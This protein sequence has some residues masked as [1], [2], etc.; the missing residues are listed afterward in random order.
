[1][2]ENQTVSIC[3]DGIF[4]SIAKKSE[5]YAK[6]HADNADYTDPNDNLIHCGKCHT[7]KQ[8]R[9]RNLK[10][11]GSMIV[12][13][14]CRCDAEKSD[15]EKIRK[16]QQ[17]LLERK[18][19]SK[20]PLSF[21]DADF[22]NIED[23]RK[24]N[25]GINYFK[26]FSKIGSSGLLLCGNVGTGKSY[27]ASCIV[28]SLMAEKKSIRWF[29]STQLVELNSFLNEED[30]Y[31]YLSNISN[32]DLIIID[33]LGAERGSDYALEQVYSIIEYRI[34]TGKPMI[35]TTNLELEEMKSAT[36]IRKIRTYDRLFRVCFPIQF[37]GVSFRKK[38]ARDN[39]ETM[40]ELLNA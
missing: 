19:A 37:H 35:I 8:C 29:Q 34:S 27:L 33:D 25:N 1:M 14:V 22:N 31:R 40:N 15:E 7:P 32:P 5:E 36:D 4:E 28:N 2:T 26:N 6:A 12:N 39:F 24:R 10:T 20:I 16:E 30:Y 21:F 13:C 11:G 18:T 38:H 23:V 3:F 9:I 17:L